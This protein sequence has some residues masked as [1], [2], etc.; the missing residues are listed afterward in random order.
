MPHRPLLPPIA[1]ALLVAGFAE[2]SAAQTY[3]EVGKDEGAVALLRLEEDRIS[4]S[5]YEELILARRHPQSEYS[6]ST[7]HYDC[8]RNERTER[9]RMVFSAAS[10][11]QTFE[12]RRVLSLAEHPELSPQFVVACRRDGWDTFPRQRGLLAAVEVARHGGSTGP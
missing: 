8:E 3:V 2:A 7:V 11:P 12:P 9:F 10:N 5:I 1:V 6:E 4:S